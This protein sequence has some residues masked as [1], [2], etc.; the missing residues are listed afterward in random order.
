MTNRAN[1]F[2]LGISIGAL[3]LGLA[4]RAHAE[5]YECRGQLGAVTVVG[6]I[7]VPDDATCTLT[8][9]QVRGSIVVKSR[10]TLHATNVSVVGGIQ[11]ESPRTV[12]VRGSKFQNGIQIGKSGRGGTLRIANSSVT[13]DVQIV[14]NRGS[15][16]LQRN[17]V[18]GSVQVGKNVGGVE[19]VRNTIGNALQCQE[20]QPFPT[21]HGNVAKQKQGQCTTL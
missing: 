9:T 12:V 15:V 17:Q 4:A 14:E 10:A 7:L 18:T 13:G 20:N 6:K 19:L 11:A 8:G 2:T 21:G 3:A 16:A 1:R 5:D